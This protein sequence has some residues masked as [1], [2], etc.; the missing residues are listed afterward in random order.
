MLKSFFISSY[1]LV[2]H[3][4][5]IMSIHQLLT[6]GFN[7]YAFGLFISSAPVVL[8][9]DGL[10]LTK[11]KARTDKSL[12]FFTLMIFIGFGFILFGN[13]VN[14]G[15]KAINLILE[16]T[17][18]IGW[19]LYLYW[20]SS[21]GNRRNSILKVGNKL[22]NLSLVDL[23]QNNFETNQLTGAPS[24]LLFYRGNWC[25]LCMAQIKEIAADY[26]QLA[27]RGV[28]VVMVS[29]QPQH[30]TQKLAKRFKAPLI[31]LQ[32]LD[33]KAAKYLGICVENGLPLGMQMLGYDSDVPMPTL[34]ITDANGNI[35]FTDLTNNYRVRPEP[36]TFLRVLDQLR[37]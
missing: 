33:N 9:F 16:S 35:V 31:F 12:S 36:A 1:I 21:F 32:D 37:T 10:M 23:S 5:L 13:W 7:W 24:I 22:P 6:A 3:L 26:Q 18:P 34:I 2:A 19:L 30:Y 28:Q 15:F 17:V 11:S 20:Y 8:L 25:P 14:D 4:I 29:P 27:D